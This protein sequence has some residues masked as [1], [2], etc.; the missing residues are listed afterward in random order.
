M[1]PFLEKDHHSASSCIP[2]V[3]LPQVYKNQTLKY[4]LKTTNN[5]NKLKNLKEAP[6]TIKV[7]RRFKVHTHKHSSKLSK[8]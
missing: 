7:Y 1:N 4:I 5:F 2:F 3:S 6:K 8:S